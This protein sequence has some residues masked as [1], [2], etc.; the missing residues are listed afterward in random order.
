MKF[1]DE[2]K[3]FVKAGNGGRGC[4][5]FRREKFIP[6]GGP[7]GGNGGKGG[8]VIFVASPSYRTLLHLQYNQHHRAERGGHG[9]GNNRSGKGG[10]DI[11]IAVPVGTVIHD[12][13]T[14]ELL[15]DLSEEGQPHIIAS[16]GIGGKGNAH[17]KSSTY[18]APRFAQPGM[19]GEERTLRLELKL[20]ADVGIIGFPNVGKSTFISRISA[21]KPKIADY[22]FTTLVPNLGVVRYGDDSFVVAD[23][24]GLIEGAHRG[25]GLGTR[26]LKHIERTTVLVHILDISREDSQD[27]WSDFTAVNNELVS[28]DSRMVQ[29]P[30]IIAVNKIDLPATRER[31]SEISERFRRE[32]LILYPLSAVTGEGVKELLGAVAK[33]LA[34][35]QNAGKFHGRTAEDNPEEY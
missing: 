17:F 18:R 6:R 3:I 26:F 20:L 2:A 21:A 28:F 13:T 32:G 16:G 35:N 4:V 31:L 29:K 27:P 34:H 12:A 15:A 14:G 1:V 33:A 22:P 25:M 30:Q 11:I 7:D 9:E 5:S 8:D 23:I 24:P 10:E 19:E